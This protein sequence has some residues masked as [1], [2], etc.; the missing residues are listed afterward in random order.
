MQR[1]IKLTSVLK[2]ELDTVKVE[3]EAL[4][5]QGKTTIAELIAELKMV[6]ADTET[7]QKVAE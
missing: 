6:K 1:D 3:N 4:L 5:Q 7:L 2:E